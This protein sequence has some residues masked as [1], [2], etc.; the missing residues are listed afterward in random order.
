MVAAHV[1]VSA[2]ARQQLEWLKQ[3][4][5][6]GFQRLYLHNVHPDQAAFISTF[7]QQVLPHFRP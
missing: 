5:A 7:G 6:L 3:D 4:A 1:R 2:S